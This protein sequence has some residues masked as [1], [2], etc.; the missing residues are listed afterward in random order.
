MVVLTCCDGASFAG[1]N[2]GTGKTVTSPGSSSTGADAGNYTF[3]TRR[4]DARPT[5]RRARSPVSA[6]AVD[7]VY[8]GNTSAVVHAYP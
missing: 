6:T 7:K 2:A 3:N 8:D 5:S 1:K 4:D